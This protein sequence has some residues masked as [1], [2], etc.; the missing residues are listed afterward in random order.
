MEPNITMLL[1]AGYENK[2]F[3]ADGSTIVIQA[4][5]EHSAGNCPRCG[6]TSTRI[7]GYYDRII[8]DVPISNFTVRI[9]LTIRHFAATMRNVNSGHLARTC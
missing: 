2:E 4:A 6:Q 3:E 7:H 5:T 8:D 1:P 9:C